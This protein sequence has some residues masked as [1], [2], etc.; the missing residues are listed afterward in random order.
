MTFKDTRFVIISLVVLLMTTAGC[1]GR[2]GKDFNEVGDTLKLK[3]ARGLTIVKYRDFT[4]VDVANPWKAG[5]LLHRYILAGQDTDV[6]M[7]EGTV[8]RTPVSRA[9]VYSTVHAGLLADLGAAGSVAGVCDA[10]YIKTPW[11]NEGLKNKTIADCGNS[12]SP[13]FEKVMALQPDAILLSPFENGGGYGRLEEMDVPIIECADYMEASPLARAE[14]MKFFGLLTGRQHE[15][16]S[17]FQVVETNYLRLKQTA[18]RLAERPSVL[19]DKMD[20]STWYV[21]GG[22]STIGQMIADAGGRYIFAR[23]QKSGSIPLPFERVLSDASQ[24]DVW[25]MRYNGKTPLTLAA[26]GREHDGYNRIKA[27]S[28]GRVYG[29]NTLTTNFFEETPF[30]PDWLLADFIAMIHPEAAAKLQGNGTLRY[31]RP[32]K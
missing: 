30:R 3:Y 2:G 25:L 14:W 7:P 18:A 32:L 29:C 22:T 12:M 20:G 9:L 8:V 26:L 6:D 11:I 27:F 21:P 23:Q 15:A 28:T 24:A 16:D 1:T 10:G 17:L 5:K 13:D 19:V 4:V 31:F